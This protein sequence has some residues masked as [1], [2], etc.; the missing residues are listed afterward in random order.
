MLTLIH[1]ES[2]NGIVKTG[3]MVLNT[4]YMNE[5]KTFQTTKA[6]FRFFNRTED[7][8]GGDDMYVVTETKAALKTE[9][10]KTYTAI[11]IDLN[12]YKDNN[13]DKATVATIFNVKEI[14][15][16]YPNTRDDWTK[17]W[18][19]VNEKGWWIRKY[20]VAHYY[21][22]IPGLA[23]TGTTTTTSSTTS[24]TT[25]TSSTTTTTSTTTK[26]Q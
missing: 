11:S 6:R 13:P 24:S 7:R 19:E 23:E 22:D 3:G 8:R 16:A 14:V 15:R 18:I 12:V 2:V 25:S 17:C 5:L 26:T 10:D 4:A 20:L 1:R 21:V 9:M